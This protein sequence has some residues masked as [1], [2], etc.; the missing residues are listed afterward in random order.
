M[1][2][3]LLVGAITLVGVELLTARSATTPSAVFTLAQ[4]EAGR[5]ELV[6]NKFGACSDCHTIGLAGRVGDPAELPPLSALSDA[7]QKMIRENYKGKVPALAGPKFIGRWASR[8]TKDLTADFTRRFASTLSEDVRLNIIA[9]LLHVSGA[10]A[11]TE[12]LTLDTA[13]EIGSL[14]PT[15]VH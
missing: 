6:T 14:L 11:G 12:P 4:A 1:K 13:V 8:T 15:T 10:P 2:H 5:V 3:A 9:Y 7:T